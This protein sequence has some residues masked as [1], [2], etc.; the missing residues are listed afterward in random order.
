[1]TLVVLSCPL[2]VLVHGTPYSES[3]RGALNHLPLGFLSELPVPVRTGGPRFHFQGL[4]PESRAVRARLGRQIKHHKGN[5]MTIVKQVSGWNK[6]AR[7][8]ELARTP[9]PPL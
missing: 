3:K 5:G 9:N 7:R 8:A 2:L 1:M 4:W 6:T